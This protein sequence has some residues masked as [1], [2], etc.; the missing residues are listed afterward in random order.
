MISAGRFFEFVEKLIETDNREKSEQYEW[1][2]YLHKVYEGTFG[3]FKKEL[4][5][6]RENQTMS[7]RA[8]ETTVNHTMSILNSFNPEKNGGEA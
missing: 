4:E 8:I 1:E 3:D 7:A 2:F 6:N 5:T